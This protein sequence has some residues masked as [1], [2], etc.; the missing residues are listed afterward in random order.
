MFVPNRKFYIVLLLFS[1]ILTSL[2]SFVEEYTGVYTIWISISC[3]ATASIIVAWLIDEANCRKA[4][5]VAKENRETLFKRLFSTF[6]NSLQILIYECLVYT[7]ENSSRNWFEWTQCAIHLTEKYPEF[8][9]DCNRSIYLFFED[10]MAQ[11]IIIQS[12]ESSL[13]ENGIITRED[14][15]ALSSMI[16]ICDMARR[17]NNSKKEENETA[18][19]NDTCCKLLRNVISY[20]PT[21]KEINEKSFESTL[22]QMM[23]QAQKRESTIEQ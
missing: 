12:Q 4:K 21:M 15:E 22:Y 6:E 7:K 20:S 1:V 14:I 17:K 2:A 8:R 23:I 11:V 3:G 10:V 16:S 18:K 13:L 9:N 5:E 19:W